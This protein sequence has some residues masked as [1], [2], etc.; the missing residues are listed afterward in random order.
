MI[1][2]LWSYYP[3]CFSKN[4]QQI[5]VQCKRRFR[6]TVWLVYLYP[7]Q[8]LVFHLL[9]VLF[10]GMPA[11]PST[12][13]FMPKACFLCS[14]L[15][16]RIPIYSFQHWDCIYDTD[17]SFSKTV[18]PVCSQPQ[19][20]HA[21]MF[22]LG[23]CFPCLFP[24]LLVSPCQ[25]QSLSIPSLLSIFSLF[26]FSFLFMP[27][28]SRLVLDLFCPC[29]YHLLVF[30]CDTYCMSLILFFFIIVFSLSVSCMK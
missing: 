30:P 14:P 4:L 11:S 12:G 22:C 1:G 21:S 8:L 25:D 17:H 7:L 23:L 13:S 2:L 28:N 29:H 18:S 9:C 3:V 10:Q 20:L 15:E 16:F 6:K 5:K 27:P 19:D 24:C 26:F